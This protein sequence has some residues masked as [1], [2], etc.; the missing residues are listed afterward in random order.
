MSW[1]GC[2]LFPPSAW[3]DGHCRQSSRADLCLSELNGPRWGPMTDTARATWILT[4]STSNRRLPPRYRTRYFSLIIPSYTSPSAEKKNI[5]PMTHIHGSR[6]TGQRKRYADES[7]YGHRL[8]PAVPNC[9][10]RVPNLIGV[11]LLWQ[12]ARHGW[13]E[14]S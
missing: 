10:G 1:T 12:E 6:L 2:Y 7:C 11:G 13:P 5:F 4:T 14:L 3:M 9:C 8:F